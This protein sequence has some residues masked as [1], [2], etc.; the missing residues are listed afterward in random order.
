MS[1]KCCRIGPKLDKKVCVRSGFAEATHASLAFARRLMTV[2][3]PVIDPRAGFDE[4]VFDV[5]QCGN[6]GFRGRIAA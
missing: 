2:F 1:A 5:R 6:P 3:R 4:D